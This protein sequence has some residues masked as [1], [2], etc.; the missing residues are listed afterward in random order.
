MNM[1][2]NKKKIVIIATL[3]GL[4]GS[5]VAAEASGLFDKVSG[6][7]RSDI[8]VLVD[9]KDTILEPV[10]I[11]GQAYL[12]AKKEAAALGYDVYYN[13]KDKSLSFTS[14]DEGNGNGSGNGSGEEANY[15]TLSGIIRGVTQLPSGGYQ[16]DVVGRGTNR[17]VILTVDKD[18]KLTDANGKVVDMTAIKAGTDIIAEYGPV[19][20]LSYPGQSHAAKV[21]LGVEHLMKEDV[22]QKVEHTN[23]GW[24]V[25]LG[26]AKDGD[27]LSSVVLNAGKETSVIDGEGQPVEWES[28]KAGMKVRA[29]Y[30]PMMTKSIPPISPL[31][32]LIVPGNAISDSLSPAAQSE[33]RTLAW[34]K[35][36]EGQAQH[37][38]TKQDEAVV[39]LVNAADSGVMAT[40]DEAKK[41]LQATKD[42]G[43]KL[44]TVTYTTDQDE[45]LGPLTVVF[46]LDT[47]TFIGYNIR[48]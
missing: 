26:E 47:K 20:A 13:A 38:K 11:N 40:T 39:E 24:Q 42:N 34:S 8:K 33:F 3:A 31:F 27:S 15:M 37:L 23:D 45:L 17:W 14:K 16:L 46:D 18:T 4:L 41:L 19:M 36:P 9:G 22:I 29:Y 2:K 1:N 48:K 35:L 6:I 25:V 21:T 43:G 12:P 7:V 44:V 28:L 32:Y 30:G 10:F 5:A